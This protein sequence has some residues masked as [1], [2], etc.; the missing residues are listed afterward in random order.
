MELKK[1]L[2]YLVLILPVFGQMW[3]AVRFFFRDDF[4]GAVIAL[5]TMNIMI[6]FIYK[7]IEEKRI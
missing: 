3:L 1:L 6:I 5:F 2:K 4:I 7:A